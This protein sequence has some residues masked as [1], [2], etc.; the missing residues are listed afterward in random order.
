MRVGG[1]TLAR[2]AT[3]IDLHELSSSF[4]RAFTNKHQCKILR[5][6]KIIR[7][8]DTIISNGVCPFLVFVLLLSSVCCLTCLHL[9]NSFQCC[10]VCRQRGHKA[11][12]CSNKDDIKIG[13][14]FKCGSSDHTTKK[15][16]ANIQDDKSTGDENAKAS[17]IILL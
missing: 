8:K 15:C 6:V 3:L 7:I 17:F 5:N 1:Q 12:E 13:S 2:V 4:D 9:Y 14:C 10:F 11:F 16:K